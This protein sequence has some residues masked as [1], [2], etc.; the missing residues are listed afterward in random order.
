MG[1]KL[2]TP[3]GSISVSFNQQYDEKIRK[4]L[5]NVL[6]YVGEQC[7]IEARE[8]GTYKDQTGNLRSSIGYA[9]VED[10][11]IIKRSKP[12][13][14]K[15]GKSGTKTANKYLA[16]VGKRFS[17]TTLIVVAGMNYAAYV[18]RSGKIVLSSAELLAEELVP[19][20]LKE[21]GFTTK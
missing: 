17:G 18:E 14:Y 15:D 6:E 9:I 11:K 5:I 4:V 16:E 10:G 13:Q 19:K 12:A 21:I 1:I 7:V 8:N 2:Q 20:L 3:K